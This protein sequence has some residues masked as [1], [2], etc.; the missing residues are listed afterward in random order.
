MLTAEWGQLRFNTRRL[1]FPKQEGS[2]TQLQAAT[3]RSVLL[4]RYSNLGHAALKKKQSQHT[5]LL[6]CPDL[7]YLPP[8]DGPAAGDPRKNMAASTLLL[9][10]AASALFSP[11]V[12]LPSGEGQ[13]VL[14]S[15]H[16]H[17]DSTSSGLRRPTR[18]NDSLCDAG[19]DQWTGTVPLGKGRDMFFC[20]SLATTSA[21]FQL[22]ITSLNNSLRVL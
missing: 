5:R 13:H 22:L 20:A 8:L 16:P 2:Y 12:A 17:S 7:T 3:P 10:V 4:Q 19:A 18:Q 14:T 11:V 9:A 15:T 21:L 6:L 1:G